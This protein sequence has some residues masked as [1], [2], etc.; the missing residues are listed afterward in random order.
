MRVGSS[1]RI[2]TCFAAYCCGVPLNFGNHVR[3]EAGGGVYFRHVFMRKVFP[4]KIY[5][6]NGRRR[7]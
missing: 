7:I 4:S 3:E 1:R 2:E 5:F 6:S